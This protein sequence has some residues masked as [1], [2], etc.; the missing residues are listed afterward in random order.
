MTQ[1]GDDGIEIGKLRLVAGA[2]AEIL[3]DCLHK[4]IGMAQ[5]GVRQSI[6]NDGSSLNGKRPMIKPCAAL[7]L[8]AC[9]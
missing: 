5:D 6:E 3:F 1:A 8:E 2:V 7:P 9:G 4:A